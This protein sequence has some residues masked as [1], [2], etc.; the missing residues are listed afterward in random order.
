MGRLRLRMRWRFWGSCTR[1][2]IRLTA[3]RSVDGFQLSEDHECLTPV[4]DL[5]SSQRPP[6]SPMHPLLEAVLKT[7]FAPLFPA[8]DRRRR[9]QELGAINGWES[10]LRRLCR[11][12]HLR[13]SNE[14]RVEFRRVRS[15]LGGMMLLFGPTTGKDPDVI[16]SP[17][18]ELV[19]FAE[20]ESRT[21]CVICGDEGKWVVGGGY[22]TTMCRECVD[23]ELAEGCLFR[24]MRPW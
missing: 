18:Q 20:D 10:L 1:C 8:G 24:D 23:A 2:V 11:A 4:D 9:E 16:P 7:D 19:R 12:I 3:L 22:F 15:E 21:L 6:P 5:S 13:N 14:D 17:V